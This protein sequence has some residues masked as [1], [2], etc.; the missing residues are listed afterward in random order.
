MFVLALILNPFGGVS[1]FGPKAGVSPFMLHTILM[2]TYCVCS[3][4]PKVSQTDIK[5]EKYQEVKLTKEKEVSKAFFSHLTGCGPFEDWEKNKETFL[6]VNRSDPVAIWTAFL[7]V[8]SAAEL[9]N[10]ALLLLGISMNQAGLE[11]NFSDLKIKKTQ[12]QNCLR[13]PW[14]KKMAKVGANI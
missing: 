4:P 8:A 10:C 3:Q 11:C 5:E 2:E 1:R 6:Q 13:L 7:P 9:A 14:L 12:L